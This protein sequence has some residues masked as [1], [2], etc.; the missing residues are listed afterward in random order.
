MA[1]GDQETIRLLKQTRPWTLT[2]AILLFVTAVFMILG[3]VFI[4]LSAIMSPRQMGGM[5]AFQM[6]TMGIVYPLIAF[7]YVVPAVYLIRYSSGI[8]KYANEST[9]VNLNSALR[10][11]KS[12]WKFCGITIIVVIGLYFGIIILFIIAGLAGALG[13]T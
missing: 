2:I 12:F 3:G 8:S 7:I 13:P 5:G 9:T 6:L 4:F 10:S 11:Q 1:G